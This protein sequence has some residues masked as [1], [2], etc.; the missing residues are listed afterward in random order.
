MRFSGFKCMALFLVTV[1]SADALFAASHAQSDLS[2]IQGV[3]RGKIGQQAIVLEIGPVKENHATNDAAGDVDAKGYPIEGRYFYVRHGVGILLKGERQ[4]DGSVVLKEYQSMK[5]TGSQWKLIFIGERAQGVFCKCNVLNPVKPGVS[6]TA[7]SLER[8][9]AGFD[10]EFEWTD[11]GKSADRAYYDLLLEFPLKTGPE[12]GAGNG[13]AY[14]MRT[15]ERY[16]VS[17][18]RLTRFPDAAV[19]NRVNTDLEKELRQRRLRAA[20]CLFEGQLITGGQW[21]EKTRVAF[22]SRNIL[23]VVR[24][25]SWYCGGAY[26]DGAS[27]PLMYNMKTGSPLQMGDVFAGAGK[28]QTGA[29]EGKVRSGPMHAVLLALYLQHHGRSEKGCEE[30][31]EDQ[32]P[33]TFYFDEK[34]LFL[35]PDLAHAIRG[36]GMA[37]IVPY[38]ELRGGVLSEGGL[39]AN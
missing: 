2:T 30:A 27:E 1:A 15:D 19:M 8:V 20:G 6:Q 29:K 34:G 31:F 11:E 9:S 4:N 7:I 21:E 14:A 28:T 18:P 39:A 24:Q 35:E 13:I 16:P 33:V 38:G 25:A 37:L 26:P 12:I 10:P 5:A 23:S 32:P 17:L 3:Y 22:L 36:C